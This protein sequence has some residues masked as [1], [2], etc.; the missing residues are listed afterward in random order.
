MPDRF[1]INAEKLFSP[2]PDVQIV[3]SSGV[4]I[5]A[6]SSVLSKA[7]SVP[8][9]LLNQPAKQRNSSERV[10]SVP[11]VPTEVVSVFVRFMYTARCIRLTFVNFLG[12]S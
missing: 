7:S 12:S 11:E 3:T 9:S 10:I 4:H 6:H 5:P 8:E 2:K 1:P